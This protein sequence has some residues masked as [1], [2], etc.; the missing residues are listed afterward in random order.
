MQIVSKQLTDI[1]TQNASARDEWVIASL[2][3]LPPGSSLLDVG[4]GEQRYRSYCS[5]LRYVSQDFCQYTGDGDGRAL[6]TGT[7]NTRT[8]DIV[9]D[10]AAIPVDDGSFD[11]VLCTEVLEHVPDPLAALREFYRVLKRGGELILTAPFCSVTHMAPYHFYSGFNRYFYLYHLPTFGF[12][13]L[14]I[15]ANG[16]YAEYMGQELRRTLTMHGRTPFYIKASIAI[17]LRFIGVNRS[18][19]DPNGDLLCYGYHVRARKKLAV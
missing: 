7:W 6:Q 19:V 11:A 1:G 18:L 17:L 3:R 12:T 15:N 2:S 8:I 13:V 5:H 10:I 14:E 16:N 4:A 9:S